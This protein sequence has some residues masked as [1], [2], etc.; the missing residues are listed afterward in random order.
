[1]F[2]LLAFAAG[3]MHAFG[4]GLHLAFRFAAIV[5]ALVAGF[6]PLAP[7][8]LLFPALALAVAAAARLA[9]HAAFGPMPGGRA[10]APALSHQREWA[11][12]ATFYMTAAVAG[13]AL[14][15]WLGAVRA[16]WIMTVPLVAMQPD[17]AT[18]YRQ[19]IQFAIGT[20]WGVIA[21]WIVSREIRS[22][23]LLS[24][25]V[26]ILA[27]AIPHHL[28]QRFWLQ[29]SLIAL[30][31]LIVYGLALHDRDV[32]DGLM[33]ERLIDILLGSLITIGAT[34]V[35]FSKLSPVR[36]PET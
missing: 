33:F 4:K 25:L 23:A 1:V 17:P 35:A 9:D 28:P 29:T 20:V 19:A 18:S 27:A 2:G 14:G 8:E 13:L 12:F 22:V 15:V 5:L 34:A 32:L 11:W 16:L 7:S 26:V 31:L 6:P 36:A 30:V 24:A 10:G 3:W 21:A